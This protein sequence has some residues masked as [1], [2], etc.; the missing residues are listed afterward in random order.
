MASLQYRGQ[1][2][3]KN[4][5]FQVSPMDTLEQRVGPLPQHELLAG[6]Q[7]FSVLTEAVSDSGS[8]GMKG[9]RQVERVDVQGLRQLGLV[10]LLVQLEGVAVPLEEVHQQ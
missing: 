7:I 2:T 3:E 5:G 9:L 10:L 8:L 4:L 1:T 6:C